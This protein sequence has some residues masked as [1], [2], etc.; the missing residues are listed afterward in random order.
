VITFRPELFQAAGNPF[1]GLRPFQPE[2]AHLYFGREQQV[3]ELRQRLE[4]D[5]F[6]GVVGDS[7]VGKSSLVSAGLIPELMRGALAA[8]YRNWRLVRFQPGMAPLKNLAR[9][10]ALSAGRPGEIADIES[11]LR[12]SSKGLLDAVTRLGLC[13]QANV[14]LFADQFEELFAYLDE[15]HSNAAS[16]ESV[17]Y[18]RQLLEA[19]QHIPNYLLLTMRSEYLGRCV[20]FTGLPEAMNRGQYLVPQ[21]TRAQLREAIVG[22][23][24]VRETPIDE[25]LVQRLLNEASEGASVLSVLQHALMRTWLRAEQRSERNGTELELKLED[26]VSAQGVAAALDQHGNEVLAQLTAPRRD[27]A[28]LVFEAI[29]F[30]DLAGRTRRRRTPVATLRAITGA[31]LDDL[32]EMTAVF[33]A[34]ECGIISLQ[35]EGAFSEETVVDLTHESV[36]SK[37]KA[38]AGWIDEEDRASWLFRDALTA[39]G[40]NERG[41]DTLWRGVQLKE[42]VE[43]ARCPHHNAAWAGRYCDN[44]ASGA[45][46]ITIVRNFIEKS[47]QLQ[48]KED[49][50]QRWRLRFAVALSVL[51]AASCL[52][53]VLL[54]AQRKLISERLQKETTE[55]SQTTAH[56]MRTADEKNRAYKDLEAAKGDAE[57]N[58]RRAEQNEHQAVEATQRLGVSLKDTIFSNEALRVTQEELK[59][60]VQELSVVNG[61]VQDLLDNTQKK[62]EELQAQAVELEKA[63]ERAE[64]LKANEERLRRESAGD[65]ARA[66]T[67]DGIRELESGDLL[68]A[69]D[70]SVAALRLSIEADRVHPDVA[71]LAAR[72]VPAV[73]ARAV[74]RNNELM[75]FTVVN[76]KLR[77]LY[78]SGRLAG[79]PFL[80]QADAIPPGQPGGSP[81]D[82]LRVAYPPRAVYD[83]FQR[84]FLDTPPAGSGP[85]AKHRSAVS[86]D[87]RGGVVLGYDDGSAE[88]ISIEAAAPNRTLDLVGA[89]TR[90][91][92]WRPVK[93]SVQFIAASPQSNSILT[94]ASDASWVLTKGDDLDAKFK[95]RI[96]GRREHSGSIKGGNVQGYALSPD[97]NTF[98]VVAHDA[99]AVCSAEKKE[100]PFLSGFP[101]VSAMGFHPG[102]SKWTIGNKDG[103]VRTQDG[104]DCEVLA[105]EAVTSLEWSA[106]GKRLAVGGERGSLVALSGD[107]CQ[108]EP[109]GGHRNRV[110]KLQWTSPDSFLSMDDDKTIRYWDL[111]P[112]PVLEQARKDVAQ[113]H[114]APTVGNAKAAHGS[115][116]QLLYS[117]LTRDSACLPPRL[118]R[119]RGGPDG[120]VSETG[121]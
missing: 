14:L 70:Q 18:V 51:L 104:Q 99:A 28:R 115:L 97:P 94:I 38:L 1:L 112:N 9:G 35:P 113:L 59:K 36:M 63:K 109:L 76:G 37:W 10:L 86:M 87:P 72:L 108:G 79:G 66:R 19:Y 32:R 84:A 30:K 68:T 46:S 110:R 53:F 96:F 73:R 65:S 29:T 17:L 8:R 102:K 56:L 114:A 40:R 7:G 43:W 92:E 120:R 5:R 67:I 119:L 64:Q 88:W 75:D 60:N 58:A 118:R 55:L 20:E 52:G 100:C 61:K 107:S 77:A 48:A 98:G 116:A 82:A 24:A 83:R 25:A 22:P 106:D 27:L 101:K 42:A 117:V 13:E 26:Y 71:G 89:L 45:A 41:E 80:C 103:R 31:S 23:M 111:S 4:V 2:N 39:A 105:N 62:N 21:L 95:A 44:P 78:S 49:S 57:R 12:Q 54:A 50:A 11:L 16:Q 93:H 121:R 74:F 47:A 33:A 81:Y 6:V 91:R 15:S 3:K 85:V 34:P 90:V 69:L